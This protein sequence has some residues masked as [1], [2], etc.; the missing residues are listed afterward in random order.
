MK[1]LLAILL[2]IGLLVSVAGTVF[3]DGIPRGFE[4]QVS[5]YTRVNDSTT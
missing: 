1:K 3:A 5:T 2:A 4:R